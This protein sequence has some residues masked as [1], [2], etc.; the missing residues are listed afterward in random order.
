[1]TSAIVL[2]TLS[3]WAQNCVTAL[4]QATNTDD[5]DTAFAGF[6]ANDVE[7][8]VVNGQQL[9]K[10]QLKQQ[11]LSSKALETSAQVTYP[12]TL[13]VPSSEEGEKV[14]SLYESS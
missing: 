12:G 10:D 13:E 3:V 14:R 9:T 5:F 7:S 8:I 4:F 6:M 11:L 1:M 2:P